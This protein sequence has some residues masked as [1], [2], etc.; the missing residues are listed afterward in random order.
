MA[1]VVEDHLC[2]GRLDISWFGIPPKLPGFTAKI[3]K[4]ITLI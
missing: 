2:Q 4:K 3:P 1:K